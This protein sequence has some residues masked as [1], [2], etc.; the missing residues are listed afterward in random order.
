MDYMQMSFFVYRTKVPDMVKEVFLPSPPTA[1]FTATVQKPRIA[2][3]SATVQKRSLL[4]LRR[5]G[6]QHW[7]W[8]AKFKDFSTICA[9]LPFPRR[10]CAAAA[11][12]T[13]DQELGYSHGNETV[14]PKP[15]LSLVAI[16]N[17]WVLNISNSKTSV[18]CLRAAV[19]EFS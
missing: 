14:L 3:F 9:L 8:I 4:I 13:N 5:N 18:L 6:S 19:I 7:Q 10:H 15:G 17:G 12:R 11:L 16:A 2:L 1:G